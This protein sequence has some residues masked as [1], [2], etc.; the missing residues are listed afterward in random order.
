GVRRSEIEV[1]MRRMAEL[2]TQ[3]STQPSQL[4][5][6]LIE[7]R[8]NQRIAVAHVGEKPFEPGYLSS[9]LALRLVRRHHGGRRADDCVFKIPQGKEVGVKVRTLP[10]DDERLLLPMIRAEIIL[11]DGREERSKCQ[12]IEEA[13]GHL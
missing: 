2:C 9:R 5:F 6:V 3:L 7:L 12:L 10:L 4:G 11:G 1:G 8:Q 13:A